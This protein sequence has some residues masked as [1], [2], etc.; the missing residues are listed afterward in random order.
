[1]TQ[2]PTPTAPL[3]VEH[4]HGRPIDDVAA[5][6]AVDL[7]AGLLP[8]EV[9]RRRSLAGRNELEG[10]HRPTLP[11]ILF[12]AATEP[13]VIL[14]A[15]AGVLAVALGEVRDGL[16]VL[17]GLIPIVGAGV[18]TEYRGERALE[19][20]RE[21]SAPRARVR[22]TGE[23][24][25]L[26]AADLVPGDV[27]LLRTG[28]IVPADLRLARADRLLL[29]TS[30]LTGESV[31]E[32]ASTS[33]APADAPLAERR[34]MA[35]SGTAVV[36]GRGEGIAVATGGR[37]EV[38]RIAGGLASRVRRR[39]PLQ[40]ELDR[41]VRI[42]LVVAIGLIVTTSG[43]GFI[44]GNPV[45]ANVLA[46]ISAAIARACVRSVARTEMV[47]PLT[48]TSEP[49][50]SRK[51]ARRSSSA[52][53]PAVWPV[54]SAPGDWRLEASTTI[55]WRGLVLAGPPPAWKPLIARRL[56]CRPYPN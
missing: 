30:V 2:P 14:L 34:S 41:L 21:A 54:R 24:L 45:G 33:P 10:E 4:P 38:G 9:E 46:G 56:S 44:R 3:A 17:A 28:D 1:M 52:A 8:S 13:F 16:L 27:V 15:V 22:R 55:A 29:D 19:A 43:L 7:A 37:T 47:V 20:L 26:P 36:G 42:L 5:T 32:P 11:A 49:R 12:D 48:P 50:R 40:R 18:V 53:E 31:P 25:D 6:L 39:S 51:T 35:F 23:V